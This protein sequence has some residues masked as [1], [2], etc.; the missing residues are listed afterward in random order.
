[1]S[2]RAEMVLLF[3]DI[4]LLM[5][6]SSTISTPIRSPGRLHGCQSTACTGEDML[7]L[8]SD[9][10][11]LCSLLGLTAACWALSLRQA[12]C[13]R[14]E[15]G[16]EEQEEQSTVLQHDDGTCEKVPC[17]EMQMICNAQA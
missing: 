14:R 2:V 9:S 7:H 10:W 13:C 6:I 16:A 3:P 8:L 15:Y 1:M 4:E 17:R 11:S 12:V 5:R